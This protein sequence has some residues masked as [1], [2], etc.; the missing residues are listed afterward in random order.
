MSYFLEKILEQKQKRVLARKQMFDKKELERLLASA[1]PVREVYAE[2]LRKE[3][4]GIPIIAEL[5]RRSPSKGEIC[6]S[7]SPGELAKRYEQGGARAVS[8]LC[9]EDYFGGSLEDLREAK[10]A[11]SSPV[12]CKDFIFCS[13]QVLEARIYG[14]DM[15]LLIASGLNDERLKELYVLIKEMGMAPLVEV[16]NQAE[17]EKVLKLGARLIGINN[18]NLH[19]LAVDLNTTRNL[20]P[21]IPKDRIVISESGF[22]RREEL[23]EMAGLG[24]KAFLIGH[25]ILSSSAPEDKLR[26]LVY[27]QG[28]NLRD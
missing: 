18:R 21:L 13:F 11:V 12:L 1:I 5:K 28:Q 26:E 10:R 8:V 15:V 9:E 25:S 27:G 3:P 22:S 7:M 14:A 24:V 4:N 23:E 20:V 6:A 17:L 16:H 2:L 19:T